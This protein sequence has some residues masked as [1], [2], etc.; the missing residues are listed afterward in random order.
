MGQ[1]KKSESNPH[2][3]EVDTKSKFTHFG[4]R[5]LI[6]IAKELRYCYNLHNNWFYCLPCN[7]NNIT[8]SI[9]KYQHLV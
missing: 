5:D 8:I 2:M 6:S 9:Y 1:R 4:V 7:D 3:T